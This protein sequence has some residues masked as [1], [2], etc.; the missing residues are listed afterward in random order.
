MNYTT[1]RI[2][3]VLPRI[4]ATWFLP[5]LQREFVWDTE[6]ICNFFDSL[7][8]DY[9]ISSLLLWS[10]PDEA[11]EDIE[12]Y[13]FIDAASDFGKHNARDRAFGAKSL[14][15]VLDGQQR[16]TSL[17]VGLKGTYEVKRRYSRT[18]DVHRLHLDL[19]RNGQVPDD[20]GEVAYGFA[21]RMNTGT[22]THGSYW[23]EVGRIL[24][25]ETTVQTLVD[26]LRAKLKAHHA[27]D[28]E[29]ALAEGNLKRLHAVV[30]SDQ[31]VCYHT[32]SHG[33]HERMLEIFV[34]ANSGGK[35]LSKP[36][37]LLS[38][39]TVHWKA[40]NARDEIKDFVDQTNGI[41]NRGIERAKPV[42]SQDF[43]LKS[44]LVLLDAPV[45]YRISSFNKETCERIADYWKDIKQAITET[46]E[47]ANWFGINGMT[48]T[49]ANALIPVAYY[50][51]RNPEIR[52][53]SDGQDDAANAGR[54]R[55][56]LVMALLNGI[57]SGSSDSM[58]HKARSVLMK[59]GE[60]GRPFPTRELDV[61]TREARRLP[62]TD[63][64]AIKNLLTLEYGGST[65]RLALTLLFDER[66]WGTIAHDVD[67]IFPQNLFR[68]E[69]KHHRSSADLIGNLTLLEARENN[70]KKAKPFDEWIHTREPA[71]LK[72]HLIPDD[73][74]LWKPQSFH[75]F[76]EERNRLIL[77]RL[78]DVLKTDGS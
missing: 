35:P 28:D 33:D 11:R 3:D 48:L 4:N 78:F 47:A 13:R 73:P 57:F 24:R 25:Y 70:E 2:S 69:L 62:T 20:Q 43:V 41:L 75:D 17:L 32:E 63:P 22:M 76:L 5:A 55:R 34:R 45:A 53:R 61:A 36:D 21:F 46:V 30:F 7:M 37:L 68:Q 72:R 19:L 67:H 23:F 29:L 77:G 44:S 38:N 60:N 51:Y 40:I 39:L 8:R 64:N 52:L 6:R 10:V 54:I 12:V 59:Y 9:P 49:S 27:S 15:F 1:E 71:Y 74:K 26:D 66:A 58:L 18:G 50:L 65:T 42:L 56:W 14:T 16:L 31:T